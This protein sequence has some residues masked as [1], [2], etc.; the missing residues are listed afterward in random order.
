MSEIVKTGTC[1]SLSG[2]STLTYTIS[3][4]GKGV[5]FSLVENTLRGLFS[6]EPISLKEMVPT[7][8]QSIT[9]GSL[10][11]LFAKKSINSGGFMLAVLRHEG[12][13]TNVEGKRGS[14]ITTDPSAFGA[15]ITP[16]KKVARS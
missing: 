14:Y 1:P 6:K 16:N 8:G 10:N 12:L 15:D 2:Q 5:Y 4:K 3:R 11:K 9:S 7:K 13:V